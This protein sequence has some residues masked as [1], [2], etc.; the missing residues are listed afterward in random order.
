MKRKNLS[1]LQLEKA[2]QTNQ[3]FSTGGGI[4]LNIENRDIL[5]NNGRTF[6]LET[7]C[8]ILLN[9][10]NNIS[11]RP[12][13]NNKNP[14][15]TILSIWEKRKKYYYESSDYIINT[16]TLSINDVIDEIVQKIKE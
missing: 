12:L 5:K 8:K 16:N 11:T 10:I 14:I 7:D 1:S 13:L 6:F 15:E 2:K 9:R 4:I 3:V